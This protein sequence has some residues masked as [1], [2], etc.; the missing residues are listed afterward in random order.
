M[1]TAPKAESGNLGRVLGSVVSV[2]TQLHVEEHP[3]MALPTNLPAKLQLSSSVKSDER[4]DEFSVPRSRKNRARSSVV[5]CPESTDILSRISSSDRHNSPTGK[6]APLLGQCSSDRVRER[7]CNT[8]D[9]DTEGIRV[10][11][12]TQ[13]QDE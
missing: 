10:C 5:L 2:E 12:E 7:I 3:G 13:Q 9:I 8:G 1:K 4:V 11:V 6:I